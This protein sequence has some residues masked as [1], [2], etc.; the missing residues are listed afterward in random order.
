MIAVLGKQTPSI[1][2][3][4]GLAGSSLSIIGES[5]NWFIINYYKAPETT[6][7]TGYISKS[8][9]LPYSYPSATPIKYTVISGDTL[10]KIAVKYKVSI[11]DIVN[12]N[13]LTNINSLYVGEQLLI[14]VATK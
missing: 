14:P 12:L 7:L 6:T 2:V 4:D 9:V 5:G 11:T 3:Q 8:L 13:K 1:S 10:S